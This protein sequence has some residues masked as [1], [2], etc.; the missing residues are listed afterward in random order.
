MNLKRALSYSIGLIALAILL[1]MNHWIFITWFK[2]SYLSWYLENGAF[3]GLVA[4][5]ASEVWKDI[6]N[7][8]DLISA[9]PAEY[10]GKCVH[11]VGLF[12]FT[13]GTNLKSNR[14]QPKQVSSFDIY[15]TLPLIVVIAL[16]LLAWLIVIVPLQYFV[17]LV[18]GA[19]ARVFSQSDR[20][21]LVTDNGGQLSVDEMAHNQTV[22]NNSWTLSLSKKPIAVTNIF[23]AMT[24][25]IIGW[26][27]GT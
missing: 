6:E 16:V 8:P 7:H 3:I 12:V 1:L 20:V 13:L 10:L 15:M 5:I 17:F 22:P 9:H 23:V 25:L 24:L 19:P 11:L 2:T 18:C 21:A 4:A 26:L 14:N 27:T